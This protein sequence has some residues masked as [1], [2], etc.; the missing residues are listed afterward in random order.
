MAFQSPSIYQAEAIS[1]LVPPYAV[2]ASPT[3]SLQSAAQGVIILTAKLAI[4]AQDDSPAM[5]RFLCGGCRKTLKAPEDWS[6]R[7]WRWPGAVYEEAA[8]RRM[9]IRLDSG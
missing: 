1:K 9:Q 6:V 7:F 3:Q 2:V 4:P 8:S 5:I